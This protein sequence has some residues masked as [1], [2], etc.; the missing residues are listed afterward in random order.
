MKQNSG[1]ITILTVFL[2][3]FGISNLQQSNPSGGAG[4]ET[5][6]KS[7]SL[8]K[9]NA[10]KTPTLSSACEEIGDRLQRFFEKKPEP[11]EKKN[12]DEQHPGFCYESGKGPNDK[13]R[14]HSHPTCNLS[15]PRCRIP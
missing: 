2:A 15:S 6:N 7:K 9:P 10:S 3:V 1:I 5:T 11:D 12:Q 13:Y 8:A 4:S 14:R